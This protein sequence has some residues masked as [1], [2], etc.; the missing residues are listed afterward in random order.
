MSKGKLICQEGAQKGAEGAVTFSSFQQQQLPCDQ[1]WFCDCD[2]A[3]DRTSQGN[4]SSIWWLHHDWKVNGV[5]GLPNYWR[6][7]DW[8]VSHQLLFRR[9]EHSSWWSQEGVLLIGGYES[10]LTTVLLTNDGKSERRFDLA[11]GSEWVIIMKI[12]YI[13]KIMQILVLPA[14]LTREVHS[15][16]LVVMM[17]GRLLEQF[18]DTTSTGSLKTCSPWTILAM[19]MAAPNI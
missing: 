8:S 5:C 3:T 4:K 17:M 18:Q 13:L 1:H 2:D 6:D 11:H 7:D 10:S 19:T 16:W 14:W 9:Y 15:C 12:I